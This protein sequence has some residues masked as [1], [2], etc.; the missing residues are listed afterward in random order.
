MTNAT[1]QDCA[2][3]A[4]WRGVQ[5]IEASNVFFHQINT[6]QCALSLHSVCNM[7]IQ[8]CSLY[9]NQELPI[10]LKNSTIE[11]RGETVF[12]DNT[13]KRGGG[14]ALYNSKV[15][16][17]TASNAIFINNTAVRGGGLA[18]LHDSTV[19]FSE[20][21]NVTF[22]NNSAKKFGG[23]IYVHASPTVLI[24]EY[25]PRFQDDYYDIGG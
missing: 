13:A 6:H 9:K 1:I 15:V 21:S 8:D 22:M 10:T 25:Q 5:I 4:V 23:A 12:K 3:A 7:T 11:L 17:G 18:L 24:E 16:F 2:L 19:T 14:L 20:K